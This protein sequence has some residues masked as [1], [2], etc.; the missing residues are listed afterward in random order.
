MMLKYFSL[1]DN[2]I[3]FIDGETFIKPTKLK[4]V[5]LRE[6]ECIDKDFTNDSEL[7]VLIQTVSQTCEQTR[8]PQ[9]T[10]TDKAKTNMPLVEFLITI[11]DD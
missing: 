3:I 4:Y 10:T 1:D 6:N 2:N 7:A 5:W 9:D 8:V 11:I